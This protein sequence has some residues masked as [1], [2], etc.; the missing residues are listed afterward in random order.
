MWPYIGGLL[1]TTQKNPA[2]RMWWNAGLIGGW[3]YY[4]VRLLGKVGLFKK[5]LHSHIKKY[6]LSISNDA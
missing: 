6:I 5:N 1:Y 3:G 4:G 2:F